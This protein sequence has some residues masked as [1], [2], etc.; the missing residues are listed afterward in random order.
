MPPAIVVSDAG[1]APHAFPHF[2]TLNVSVRGLMLHGPS[3]DAPCP[4]ALREQTRIAPSTAV[5]ARTRSQKAGSA[6]R[7]RVKKVTCAKVQRSRIRDGSSAH[8]Q[9][10]RKG[11]RLASPPRRASAGELLGPDGKVGKTLELRW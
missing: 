6:E 2:W 5:R 1:S 11:W 9:W 4:V 10:V 7:V 8:L 3:T